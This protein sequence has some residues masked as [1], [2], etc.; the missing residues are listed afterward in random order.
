M[1]N[2]FAHSLTSLGHLPLCVCACACVRVCVCVCARDLV[3][4]YRMEKP[5]NVSERL[6]ELMSMCWEQQPTARCTF[7]EIRLELEE[8][9]AAP[10]QHIDDGADD[11]E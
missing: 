10:T 4:R 1:K 3:S 5:S 7:T 9:L 6:F 2:R 8:M 11:Y